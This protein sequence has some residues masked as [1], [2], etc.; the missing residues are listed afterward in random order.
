MPKL[1]A[2]VNITNPLEMGY[3]YLESIKSFANLC[4]EVI[5]V[6]GG[7]N[8]G[9]L[10]KIKE[11]SKVKII[12]GEKWEYDFDWKVMPRNLQIGLEA[13][14]GDWAF[15][16]DVDYIFH[17]DNVKKM[18]DE[19]A[20]A[21]LAAIELEKVN[22]VLVSKFFSKNFYPFLINKKDFKKVS[23]GF[24]KTAG[25]TY[26]LSFLFPINIKET[27]NGI[28]YGEFIRMDNMRLHR[29][30]IP[31]YTY[32]FTFMTKK[33]VKEQR[34]RFEGSLAKYK[35]HTRESGSKPAFA[36]F[37]KMMR[38]RLKLCNKEMKLEDH[39]RFIRERVK[40]IKPE[41]F[42]YNGWGEL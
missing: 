22:S 8:D 38:I 32:D 11:I 16:F 31:V 35:G 9:S 20:K 2:H 23:Y 15:K 26:G 13:C 39:S 5:V 37:M 1:S 6:D 41:M 17:E 12:E 42:G 14:T 36:K 25:S 3:P 40:N 7:S 28:N 30:N 19:I 27:K 29:I 24:G 4:D 18:K 34:E 33:Q 10:K 21:H